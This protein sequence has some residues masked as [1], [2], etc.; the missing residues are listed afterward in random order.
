ME[1][2]NKHLET[3]SEIRS[4]MERSS[5]FISLSGL[6]GVAAGT[7]AL[8]GA[9]LAYVYLDMAPFDY[10][11]TYYE[12]AHSANKWGMHYFTFLPLMA[13]SS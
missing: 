3:L 1:K 8:I 9:A 13:Y 7:F 4:I 11:R 2:Q 5:R 10:N 6:S 12:A